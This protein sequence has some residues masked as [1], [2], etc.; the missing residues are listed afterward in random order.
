M[1]AI[2]VVY[3]KN[4]HIVIEVRIFGGEQVQLAIFFDREEQ[5]AHALIACRI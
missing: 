4:I 3:R 5:Q 1:G 2:F